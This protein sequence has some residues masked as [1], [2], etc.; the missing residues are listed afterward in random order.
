[1]PPMLVRTS[2][3]LAPGETRAWSWW[4]T[5]E[6][7]AAAA[8]TTYSFFRS[9]GT[10]T[11]QQTNMQADGRMPSGYIFRCHAVELVPA[12]GTVLIGPVVPTSAALYN[13]VAEGSFARF[14]VGSAEMLNIDFTEAN[15]ASGIYGQISVGGAALATT[16]VSLTQNGYPA[17]VGVQAMDPPIR[18]TE[19][20]AFRIDLEFPVAPVTGLAVVF[21]VKCFIVGTLHRPWQ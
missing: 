5:I 6:I 20:E 2:D 12:R 4:D 3:V 16:T 7:P 9:V 14:W 13:V 19:K 17:A 21:P 8:P 15:G 10:K 1:M 18:L 11:P